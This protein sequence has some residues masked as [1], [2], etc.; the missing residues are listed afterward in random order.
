MDQLARMKGLRKRIL[1]GTLMMVATN[2]IWHITNDCNKQKTGVKDVETALRL[3]V[4]ET[5]LIAEWSGWVRPTTMKI[6]RPL[7]Q[8]IFSSMIVVVGVAVVVPIRRVEI[9]RLGVFIP[10]LY[11]VA[12]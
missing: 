6:A 12:E 3:G 5:R 1:D 9:F 2:G 7:V 4:R 11:P 8:G 10:K